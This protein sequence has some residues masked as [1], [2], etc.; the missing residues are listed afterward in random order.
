MIS[1]RERSYDCQCMHMHVSLCKSVRVFTYVYVWLNVH[2][3]Y[4]NE[5]FFF[6]HTRSIHH[7]TADCVWMRSSFVIFCWLSWPLLPPHIINDKRVCGHQLSADR[8]GSQCSFVYFVLFL[9]IWIYF[10]VDIRS[11]DASKTVNAKNR[12][13]EGNICNSANHIYLCKKKW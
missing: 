11:I 12:L 13:L 5:G 1:V 10:I 9:I 3:P 8:I 7:E 4:S 6:V 2:F